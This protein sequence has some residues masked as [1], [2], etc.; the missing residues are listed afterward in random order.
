MVTRKEK[1][2]QSSSTAGWCCESF[3]DNLLS[4]CDSGKKTCSD[5]SLGDP[6][7]GD[8][9]CPNN[10][11]SCQQT[12]LVANSTFYQTLTINPIGLSEYCVWT[13]TSTSSNF[14]QGIYI[15][16][17]DM[18]YAQMQVFVNVTSI[19][20]K[21][22]SGPVL[23][24]NKQ[25]YQYKIKDTV[26]I[27][28]QSSAPNQDSF[29]QLASLTFKYYL[30]DYTLDIQEI[31]GDNSSTTV[32]NSSSSSQ[33]DTGTTTTPTTSIID[34]YSVYFNAQSFQVSI[35]VV[36]YVLAL[37]GWMILICISSC[38]YRF[39]LERFIA[40]DEYEARI[41]SNKINK[42]RREE[43][44]EIVEEMEKEEASSAAS[45]TEQHPKPKV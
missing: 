14:S 36:S 38:L 6:A 32:T 7:F 41:H 33:N 26:M 3:F 39:A 21:P 16:I 42:L 10:N 19:N 23:T 25:S 9:V 11:P 27:I 44:E 5:Q 40:P 31:V 4:I 18:Q 28:F 1:Y 29:E 2:C 12:T 17:L 22:A 45:K 37:F 30:S 35:I 34:T 13:L 15:D 20:K 8:L 43:D 24:A